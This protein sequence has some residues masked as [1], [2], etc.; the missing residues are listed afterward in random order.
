M[1]KSKLFIKSPEINIVLI[2][3]NYESTVILGLNWYVYRL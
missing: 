1:E 3:M 2:S